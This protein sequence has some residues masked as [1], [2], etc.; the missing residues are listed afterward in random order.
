M[1]DESKPQIDMTATMS[2]IAKIQELDLNFTSADEIKELVNTILQGYVTNAHRFQT[3]IKLYSGRIDI[4]PINFSEI[5]CPPANLAPLG[6]ANLAGQPILYCCTA[7]DAVFFELQPI[8]GD[9]IVVTHWITTA[10]LLVNHVGYTRRVFDTLESKRQVAGWGTEP[11]L[12]AKA[13]LEEI[14]NFLADVFTKAVPPDEEPL[15]HKLTAAVADNLFAGEPFDGLLYPSL[16]MRANAD[17]FALKPS[18]AN[19]HL[20]FQKAEFI[21]ITAIREFGYDFKVLDTAPEVASSGTIE[22]YAAPSIS[23]IVLSKRYGTIGWQ[24]FL[25]QKKD[26]L[27]E[28]DSAKESNANRP[29][30]TEHGNVAEASF[31]KWLREYL[32]KKYGI[33]SGFIIPDVRSINYVLR[34]FDVIIFDVLNSP[35]LW[36]SNNPDKSDQGRSRAIPAEYVHAV[37]EVKATFNATSIKE[38]MEKLQELSDYRAYL[39]EHFVSGGIFF[40]VREK[41]QSSCKMAEGLFREG[42][43]GYFGGLIL[44]AEGLDPNLTGYYV[45]HDSDKET[46][47]T[48]PLVRDIGR[49]ERNDQGQPT[50]TKQGDCLDAS[51]KD[52]VWHFDKGYSPIVNNVHLN[53]AYNSFPRF[54]ID[55]LERLQGTYDQN[56]SAEKDTYGLSY[57]R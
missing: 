43:P 34:H 21:R 28:Y 6:L 35:V 53:W 50:L 44:R 4:K 25:R 31:R 17:C 30:Q 8:V 7:R 52:G 27:N 51:N 9:T 11:P 41:G 12:P 49:L 23:N 55:L 18:F 42:I 13:G 16:K 20:C 48:M 32:P 5:S 29:V 1:A 38:T 39:P 36:G 37:L 33:T 40:E 47:D 54:F 26:I 56:K 45:L 22:W 3:G 24:E 14:T 19:R 46:I 15:Y 57:M 10:P 2:L